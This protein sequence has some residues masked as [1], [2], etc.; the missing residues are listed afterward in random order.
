MLQNRHHPT[1]P[2]LVVPAVTVTL[3]P[4]HRPTGRRL[5]NASPTRLAGGAAGGLVELSV[6]PV[7]RNLLVSQTDPVATGYVY[8]NLL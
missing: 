4:P 2:Q 5:P 7:L 1:Y 8:S 3:P 6:I